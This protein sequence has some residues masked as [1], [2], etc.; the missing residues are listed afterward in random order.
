MSR[1]ET[2]NKKV[3]VE[4]EISMVR[5]INKVARDLGVTFDEAL[6]FVAERVLAPSNKTKSV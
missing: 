4:L 6:I 3:R 5:R 1:K 2:R